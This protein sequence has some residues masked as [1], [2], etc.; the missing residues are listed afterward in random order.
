MPDVLVCLFV[1]LFCLLLVCRN[2]VLLVLGVGCLL[3]LS[4][5]D[6]VCVALLGHSKVQQNSKNSSQQ[7]KSER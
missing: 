3:S 1:C 4:V 2:L 7:R 5:V 6:L